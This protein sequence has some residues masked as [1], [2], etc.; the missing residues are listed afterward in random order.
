MIE[1]NEQR[2]TPE[3]SDVRVALLSDKGPVRTANEDCCGQR[4]AAPER[5]AR[6]FAARLDGINQEALLG[7]PVAQFP[8]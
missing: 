6:N 3:Q 8:F 2:P 5:H 1:A 4:I 7:V